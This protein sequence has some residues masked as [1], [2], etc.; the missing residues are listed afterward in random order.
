MNLII[1]FCLRISISFLIINIAYADNSLHPAI[2]QPI[3]IEQI[4][5]YEEYPQIVQQLIVQAHALTLQ[6]LT[7]QYGSADPTRGGMDCSGTIF[8]LLNKFNITDVPRSGNEIYLWASQKVK[9]HSVHS[10]SF[11]S[12]EFSDLKPGDLL[13]WTGTYHVKQ[14]SSITHVMLYL[15]KNQQGQ[16]L[17][18]GASDGRTYQG[19]P[20]W[21]VSVFDFKLPN[22]QSPSRFVGYSC[23]PHLTC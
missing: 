11:D 17:M 10:N 4:A 1:K 12:A 20:M 9:V 7:Y 18:F 14:A 6:R 15:G 5:G 3:S 22:I 8:Y 16:R 2:T 23:I 13:F 21:G 19:K